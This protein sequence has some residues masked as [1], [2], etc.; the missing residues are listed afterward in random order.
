M[1]NN[2][3]GNILE[4]FVDS[5][6]DTTALAFNM[7][8][9]AFDLWGNFV[10]WLVEGK[11][12]EDV[13]GADDLDLV[14]D[15]IVEYEYH[16]IEGVR[17]VKK[18]DKVVGFEYVEGN[19]KG[20]M[21]C[22]GKDDYDD[23]V[24]F[25]MLN[26]NTMVGGASRWGKSSF[27]NVF[28]TSVMLTYTPN[29]VM[30][31]GCD[32]KKSDIY[33][34]RK[35]KHFRGMSTNKDEFMQQ[36]G[37]IKKEMDLREKILNEANCRNVI[38]YNKKSDKKMGYIIFIIDELIQLVRDN[39]CKN[40]L[41]D[42]MSISSSYGI[43]FILASQDF[44]KDTI[45]KCKMNISQTLGFHT[46]DDTDSTT[47]MGKGADLHEIK[48]KGRCK[49]DNGEKTTSTQIFFLEEEQ[50]EAYLKRFEKEV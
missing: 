36:I 17:E 1:R 37:G 34:Y 46:K 4:P 5:L 16:P 45:G 9:K 22:I 8:P 35:Y 38:K 27:L 47:L 7:I 18:R 28:I 29:E 24:W 11:R 14:I 15:N 2:S 23:Y 32:F 50:I 25:D 19:K 42:V 33:Y 26:G 20:I 21:A 31:L 48:I 3:E 44:T 10:Y 30:F 43:Y 39:E 41:H 6:L 12:F 40:I 13:E 49:F